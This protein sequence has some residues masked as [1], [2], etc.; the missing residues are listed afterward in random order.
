VTRRLSLPVLIAAVCL[1][2]VEAA[3]VSALHESSTLASRAAAPNVTAAKRRHHHR[4]GCGKFCHQAG[5]F[6]PCVVRPDG[7]QFCTHPRHPVRIRSQTIRVGRHGIIEIR[8]TC[9]RAR[10]CVGA[11]VVAGHRYYGRDDL[12]IRGHTTREVRVAVWRKGRRYL[13]HHG[14]DRGVHATAFLNESDTFSVSSR[15]T[16]LA[17][18]H[19]GR[20]CGEREDRRILAG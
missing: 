4:P 20:R 12:W 7:K 18:R 6:G 2:L 19:E 15:L 10:K 13:H 16:L 11:V 14:C 3:S 5:G 8:V 9:R 17:H 1:P